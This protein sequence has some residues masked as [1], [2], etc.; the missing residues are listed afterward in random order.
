MKSASGKTPMRQLDLKSYDCSWAGRPLQCGVPDEEGKVSTGRSQVDTVMTAFPE[1]VNLMR[2]STW[3]R[4]ISPGP[5]Q[6]A[7]R[8]TTN[9][10]VRGGGKEQNN[11]DGVLAAGEE[12]E[13]RTV[14]SRSSPAS[15]MPL[16][17]NRKCC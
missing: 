3:L 16:C 12:S 10:P 13:R 1:R 2:E 4:E 14:R 8:N 17:S 11:P 7:C 5:K 6:P 15:G 9:G